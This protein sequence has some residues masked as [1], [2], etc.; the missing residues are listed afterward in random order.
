MVVRYRCM[1]A[2]ICFPLAMAC[3]LLG[4]AAPASC[5]TIPRV[6][7]YL[8]F[9]ASRAEQLRARV[10]QAPF[11]TRWTSLRAAAERHLS[12]APSGYDDTR[13]A[14]GIAG[15][16][17]FAY[18]ITGDER[19]AQRAI[20]EGLALLDAPAWHTG[21][22][23][24]H[25]A[26]LQTAEASVACALVYDWCYDVLSATER[27]QFR[28]GV[29]SKSTEV[30]LRSVNTYSDWWVNNR[31]TNW[32][33]VCHGGCGLAALAFYD[34]DPRFA[35]AAD[36]AF[37][38]VVDFIDSAVLEDGGG[39]EGVMYNR[40]GVSFATYLH[41]AASHVF[42]DDRGV[43]QR[44]NDEMAGYWY[45]HLFGP[46]ERYANFN[47]MGENTCQG[48]YGYDHRRWEGGPPAALCALWESYLP[49]GDSLLLWG[50][51]YGGSPFYFSGV[52]PFLLIWRRSGPKAPYDMPGLNGAVLFWG[53]GQ[54]VFREPDLWT[55]FNG[56][57]T[58]NKSHYN[59]DLGTFVL[60]YKGERLVN[61]P[62]YGFAETAHHST[63]LV[64][65]AGQPRNVAASY[66]AFG[67]GDS[68]H[69][70]ASDLSSCYP[71]LT[72]FVRHLLM[73]R[74]EYLVLLDDL[75]ADTVSRYEW[76]LQTRGAISTADTSAMVAGDARRLHV[77]A[78]A[79]ADAQ[80]SSDTAEIGFVRVMPETARTEETIVTVLYP[81]GVLDSPPATA[82]NQSGTVTVGGDVITFSG[83][84]GTW[85]LA[86]VAGE[87]A[88][89][90][91]RQHERT[92]PSMR[93]GAGV[94]DPVA[95]RRRLP[96][97]LH[98]SV[99]RNVLLLRTGTRRPVNVLLVGLDGRVARELPR[100]IGE[101]AIELDGIS[102]GMYVVRA[103][104]D[105]VAGSATV[106]LGR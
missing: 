42:G 8:F 22:T 59:C 20:A 71:G 49:E 39:H 11:D 101:A 105:D 16:S 32:S 77:A 26:D 43:R 84:P 79:P 78:L 18:V 4:A 15:N 38:C 99:A 64:N 68:F 6:H 56:G 34:E 82:W 60:V 74:G 106:L 9:T 23:W 80:V 66:Q 5:D 98:V 96:G 62:G 52:S 72:R 31:V 28:E 85:R 3:A 33:G 44:L 47:D 29:L 83:G 92:L 95:R 75:A 30:Y 69:Y 102:R 103:A 14:L 54:A 93:G 55:A 24:N 36:T 37:A 88:T 90:I 58:S 53:A 19:Y 91:D 1:P 46:D 7:P 40:Y 17:A 73:V 21:Y 2:T 13:W 87:P 61:D 12:E 94:D 25:G 70:L 63:I 51:D 48:V 104:A 97:R 27:Q 100:V 67:S 10:N 89:D 57:W 86:T 41:A 65:G 76:R 81:T 50:A 45:H 35:E